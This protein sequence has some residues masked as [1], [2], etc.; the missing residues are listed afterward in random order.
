LSADKQSGESGAQIR[1]QRKFQGRANNFGGNNLIPDNKATVDFQAAKKSMIQ[2]SEEDEDDGNV[3]TICLEHFGVGEEVAW[4]RQPSC[5]HVFHRECITQWLMKSGECPMC[6]V[7]YFCSDKVLPADSSLFRG[8]G[9]SDN[10]VGRRNVASRIFQ[11]I[12]L[13]DP[14]ALYLRSSLVNHNSRERVPPESRNGIAESD[15]ALTESVVQTSSQR[16]IPTPE[17]G[18]ASGNCH[19]EIADIELGEESATL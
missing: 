15:Q 12:L 7:E 19:E 18:G 17:S 5:R 2:E 10:S 14:Y 11:E 8:L 9:H 16:R 6:R 1:C 13:P 4:S 3:C